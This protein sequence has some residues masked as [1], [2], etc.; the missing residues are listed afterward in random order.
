MQGR[1]HFQMCNPWPKARLHCRAPVTFTF[2]CE[3]YNFGG[4]LPRPFPSPLVPNP[5]SFGKCSGGVLFGDAS[6]HLFL[7]RLGVVWGLFGVV[8][9]SFGWLS[10]VRRGA[11]INIHGRRPWM[12]ILGWLFGGRL[13]LLGDGFFAAVKKP[14]LGVLVWPSF[15]VVRGRSGGSELGLY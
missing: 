3:C 14:S 10:G 15:G 9:G 1:A 11:E 13:G 6:E 8:W 4:P 12:L 2:A 7:G 5:D